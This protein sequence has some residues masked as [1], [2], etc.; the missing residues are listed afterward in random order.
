MS[1][2]GTIVTMGAKY[3]KG[4]NSYQAGHVRVYVFNEFS[5]SW[6]QRG[7]D[8]DGNYTR[9]RS[10]S[11]VAMSSDGGVVAI[12]YY[13]N[14]R[15]FAFNNVSNSWEKVG[16]HIP[17]EKFGDHV[18]SSLA[19]SSD[20]TMI[21]IGDHGNNRD[22]YHSFPGDTRVHHFDLSSRL[23]IITEKGASLLEL[24]I[25]R[26]PNETT[27]KL[28][29]FLNGDTIQ[30]GGPYHNFFTFYSERIYLEQSICHQFTILIQ[31]MMEY[32]V[33]GSLGMVTIN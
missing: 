19:I 8:I 28:M 11:S 9:V 33:I 32:V 4:G 26:Y 1:S 22:I 18:G 21:A 10:G 13:P 7:D 20:G 12:A 24:F 17:C 5:Y 30:S 27:W 16:N 15:V 29:N 23:I 14:F 3:N 31:A 6:H 25:D 2:D